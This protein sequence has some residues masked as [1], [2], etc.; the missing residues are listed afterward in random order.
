LVAC[1][2]KDNLTT[3]GFFVSFLFSFKILFLSS[4]SHSFRFC[5]ILSLQ[6]KDN[7]LLKKGYILRMSHFQIVKN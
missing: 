3:P 5:N 7:I 1:Y 6:K 4:E 2:A